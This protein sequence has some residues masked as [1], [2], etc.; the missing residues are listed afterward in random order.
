MSDAPAVSRPVRLLAVV[1]RSTVGGTEVCFERVLEALAADPGFEVCAAYPRDG[2]LAQ[3]WDGLFV[4]IPYEA[5]SLPDRFDLRAYKGWIR[6]AQLWSRTFQADAA[7]FAPDIV[8]SFTSVLTAPADVA[9]RLGVP[10]IAYVREFVHPPLARRWLWRHLAGSAAR[11]VAVSTPLAAALE[12]YAP[13][14]VRVV[15]DGVPLP[16]RQHP[17]EWPPALPLAGFYGGYDPRKGGELFVRMSAKVRET[18]PEAR[19][20]F[21]GVCAPGQEPFRDRLRA[22]AAELGLGADEKAALRFDETGDF[23]SSF[24]EN[25]VVVMPSVREGLGLV[26]IDAMSHGVP[27]VAS[28]TG[29]LPDV[30][31]GGVTGT[32]VPVGDVGGFAAAAAAIMVE[33]AKAESM[34]TAARARV[35]RLFTIE[36]AVDGLRDVVRDVVA[37]R[38]R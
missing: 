13:G 10:A 11:L 19:F 38:T 22:L 6:R 18:A 15:H 3:R 17:A 5:G 7:A 33:R 20:A 34:G 4:H 29:G 26:A 1:H 27:V 37:G 12:P 24:G 2:E 8:V 30:V 25:T 14:R 35:E 23:A 32:L 28:R 36:R 31:D 9:A 21:H 16:A